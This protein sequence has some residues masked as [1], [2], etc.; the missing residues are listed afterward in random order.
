VTAS[1]LLPVRQH[2]LLSS[3]K[4]Y[5]LASGCVLLCAEGLL[6]GGVTAQVAVGCP[7]PRLYLHQHPTSLP[8]LYRLYAEAKGVGERP[9]RSQQQEIRVG[10]EHRVGA[11]RPAVEGL[12][13]AGICI[14]HVLRFA[15]S[16]DLGLAAAP[17]PWQGRSSGRPP[18]SRVQNAARCVPH[19]PVM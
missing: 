3:G 16:A 9:G 18:T 8:M 13:F 7:L 11:R 17:R 2:K 14:Q 12:G 10:D 4:T 1:L 19:A 5:L 6:Q 15:A